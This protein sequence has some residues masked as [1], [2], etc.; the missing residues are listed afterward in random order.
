M[1]PFSTFVYSITKLL[2]KMKKL[3]YSSAL[4]KLL[5]HNLPLQRELLQSV[6]GLPQL[7]GEDGDLVEGEV[8]LA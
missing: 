6:H 4:E 8:E 3:Q 7:E 2:D 1:Q 5:S